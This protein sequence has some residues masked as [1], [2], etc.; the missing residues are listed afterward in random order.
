MS[1]NKNHMSEKNII[2]IHGNSTTNDTSTKGKDTPPL[3]SQQAQNIGAAYARLLE[4]RDQKV[5]TVNT[6]AEVKGLVEFL[7]AEL[8]AHAS[9]FLACWIAVKSE[10][11]PA[12]HLLARIGS[13]VTAIREAKPKVVKSTATT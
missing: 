4:L 8:L 1:T 6:E 13:R 2:D 7:S 3:T 12:L 5:L 11:E 10:Y 9:E